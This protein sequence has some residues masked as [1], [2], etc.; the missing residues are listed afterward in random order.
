QVV[1]GGGVVLDQLAVLDQV[2]FLPSPC[3]REG[4]A[5]RVPR[6]D[7]GHLAQPS[8]RL[9]G[10]LLGV[11]AAGD[12]FVALALG[13]ADDVDHL[14]LAEHLA[15]RDLLLQA[16]PGPV[17][18]LGH[19]ATIH[20]DLHQVCLLLPQG[21]QAHL[22]VRQHADDLAVLLHAAEVLVQ[23]PLARVVLPL[24]AVLGEGLLLRLVP[25]LVEAPLA[26][27]TDVLSEHHLEGAEAP[28]GLHVAHD[29]HDHHGWG[30]HDGHGLHHFLLVHLGARPVHLLHDVR[31]AGLVAQEGGEVHR[32][33]RVVLGDLAAVLAAALPGQEAQGPVPGH[34]E[35]PV[36]HRAVYP[37][38]RRYTTFSLT[39]IQLMNL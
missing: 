11:P 6:P 35:L 37:A 26:L 3:H 18:L 10:Q 7:A 14:V 39:I 31:Q 15:H 4:H 24:L 22:R 32:L 34:R 36:R 13:H 25:V 1:V 33:A 30:L 5:R 16:L 8:V 28:R 17:Q 23:L 38:G 27:V 12:R 19:G 9:V 20:L 2:A 21:Q 29:A